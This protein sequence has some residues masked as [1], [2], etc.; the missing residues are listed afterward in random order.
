MKP[1]LALLIS[2]SLFAGDTII[3]PN[4]KFKLSTTDLMYQ[5][6][7]QA[8][9]CGPTTF[10]H[11]QIIV[12]EVRADNAL[13]SEKYENKAGTTYLINYEYKGD[14]YRIAL[15]DSF[16]ECRLYEDIMIKHLDVKSDKYINLKASK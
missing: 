10:E 5:Y 11:R 13:I 2:L 7:Y 3:P 14:E 6:D 8:K 4:E 16:G 1:L 15:M 9:S 12:N